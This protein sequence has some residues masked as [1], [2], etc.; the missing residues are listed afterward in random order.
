M[1]S[2]LSVY[3][4][5]KINDHI[6]KDDGNLDT[7]PAS[8]WIM[9]LN[10]GGDPNT[11]N[12]LLRANNLASA[13]SYEISTSGTAYA[14]LEINGATGRAFS[15]SS[16]GLTENTATWAFTESTASWGTVTTAALVDVASG[17]S[18]NIWYYGELTAEKAVSPP[19]IFR[20]L[21][22]TFDIQL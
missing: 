18:G 13:V 12:A 19:D 15:T 16:S 10:D 9:L 22:G 3:A 7:I 6:L 1:A 20:F 21:T 5:N 2:G 14:R 11:V 17:T 8:F 4:A